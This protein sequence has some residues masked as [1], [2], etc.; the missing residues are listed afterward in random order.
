MTYTRI[1]P[2]LLATA[3][4]AQPEDK[5]FR[6]TVNVV[7]APTTV[8]DRSGRFV[9]GIQTNTFRLYDNEKLQDIKVDEI[10]QPLSLVVVIQADVAMEPILPKVKK[11]SSMLT[12][13]LSGQ[14]GEVAIM[15]FDHR[16]RTMQ[17]FTNDTEK[18][19]KAL[20]EIRVGSQYSVMKDAVRESVR[21]L[22]RRPK[23]HRKVVLLIAE[24]RDK[25]SSG[26]TR[27]ILADIQLQNVLVYTVNVNRAITTLSA[28]PGYPRPDPI[29]PG[30]RHMAAGIPNTPTS[31]ASMGAN[32][33][34]VVPVFVEIFK[35]V[36]DIFVPNP[37]EVFTKY[38]GGREY[39]FVTQK[40]LEIAIQNVSEE[41][42]S[43][44]MLS[45]NPDNKIE[46]GFHEIRVTVARPD[47][48]EMKV[49]TRP[50]Y[51]MAGVPD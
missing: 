2:A 29:P 3:L 24:T 18:L 41:L 8:T 33:G 48:G 14:D 19:K 46:G 47:A 21:L 34:S 27:E 51:W 7:V 31:V 15:A 17:D 26:K 37:A 42:H 13:L 28:K 35:D 4:F 6:A 22:A 43:Q 20:D 38:T 50:G 36:K 16:I 9:T 25:S 30:G 23:N 5:T 1:L 11:I 40:D 45:Y 32:L 39:S 12:T 44:Y 49:R 10:Y